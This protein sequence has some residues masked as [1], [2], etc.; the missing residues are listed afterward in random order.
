MMQ[1]IHTVLSCC[2][3]VKKRLSLGELE[4]D[5]NKTKRDD[6]LKAFIAVKKLP[7]T[8]PDSFFAIASYH[9]MPYKPREV[10][11]PHIP[12]NDTN[13]S[14]WGG[15]CQH[16][17]ILFPTWHRFYCLK[18]EQ[19]LQKALPGG[20]VMLPY[21]DQTS[22][23]NLRSGLPPLLVDQTVTIDGEEKPNPLLNFSLNARIPMPPDDINSDANAQYYV[24]DEGYTTVRYPFS[25]VKN[26]EHAAAMLL[27]TTK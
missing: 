8:D 18:L 10:P 3:R 13:N 6:F 24:K 27:N 12:P 11:P 14:A 20:D 7:A 22:P 2:C 26:P 5:V 16:A 4:L 9:G 17:N 1:I 19:A 25:G 23:E 15:Y 21:W